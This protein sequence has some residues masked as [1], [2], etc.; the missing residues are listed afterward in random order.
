M[1]DLKLNSIFIRN[2]LHIIS[3]VNFAWITTKNYRNYVFTL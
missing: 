2:L 3:I 1:D